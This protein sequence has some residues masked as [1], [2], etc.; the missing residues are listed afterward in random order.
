MTYRGAVILI[1]ALIAS[2]AA[3]ET[4][5]ASTD[6]DLE[7]LYSAALRPDIEQWKG[8]APYDA[9]RLRGQLSRDSSSVEVILIKNNRW[10]YPYAQVP[11]DEKWVTEDQRQ[12]QL[13]VKSWNVTFPDTVFHFYTDDGS[14]CEMTNCSAPSFSVWKHEGSADITLPRPASPDAE[15][16]P[17]V[18]AWE[19]KQPRV[20]FRGSQAQRAA[21]LAT[22]DV[23]APRSS[24][25][26]LAAREP[27]KVDAGFRRTDAVAPREAELFKYLAVLDGA[28]GPTGLAG[29]MRANSVLLKQPSEWYDF[30]SRA[31]RAGDHYEPIFVRSADDV[32]DVMAALEADEARARALAAASTAFAARFLCDRA[33]ILYMR[34]AVEEYNALFVNMPALVEDFWRLTQAKMSSARVSSGDAVRGILRK[35]WN[36]G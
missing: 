20:F 23:V 3:D 32:L 22:G 14:Y 17:A 11:T 25:V 28:L 26:A 1:S 9:S 33:R 10:F 8:G 34:R 31:L 13:H 30:A 16:V 15:T 5:C 27:H 7:P 21:R 6:A 4:G 35:V 2:A 12:F 18:V 29:L 36:A 19:K 24:L